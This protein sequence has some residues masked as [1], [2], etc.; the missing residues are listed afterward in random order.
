MVQFLPSRT[1]TSA[2]VAVSSSGPNGRKNGIDLKKRKRRGDSNFR[3]FPFQFSPIR[4]LFTS[5]LSS[6]SLPLPSSSVYL[7]PRIT[8]NCIGQQKWNTTMDRRKVEDLA[9]ELTI[10]LGLLPQRMP[11]QS[12]MMDGWMLV[13]DN[14]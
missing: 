4:F 5:L 1:A 7:F 9:F 13:E 14:A 11:N 2:S 3:K 12:V 8:T 10:S 6:S